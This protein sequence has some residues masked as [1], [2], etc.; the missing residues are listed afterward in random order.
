MKCVWPLSPFE[1]ARSPRGVLPVGHPYT[2][3]MNR[4]CSPGYP[5]PPFNRAWANVGFISC[6]S[7]WPGHSSF[8]T[9]LTHLD[10]LS[11]PIGSPEPV[12]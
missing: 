4:I 9:T 6:P 3:H 7:R 11:G 5:L 10:L 1:A 12:P 2:L 8:R